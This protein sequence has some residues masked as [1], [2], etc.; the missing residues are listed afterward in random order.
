MWKII[1]RKIIAWKTEIYSEIIV[2]I[3]DFNQRI[4]FCLNSN[5]LIAIYLKAKFKIIMTEEDEIS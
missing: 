5:S 3:C 2:R 1:A 4:L